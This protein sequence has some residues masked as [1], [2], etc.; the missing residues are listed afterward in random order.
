MNLDKLQL[1]A[2]VAVSSA[3]KVQWFTWWNS[4]TLRHEAL[5][6][7][8]N[9]FPDKE[10]EAWLNKASFWAGVQIPLHVEHELVFKA[11]VLVAASGP[12]SHPRRHRRTSGR[13]GGAAVVQ[14]AL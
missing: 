5:R 7:P 13:G 2:T 10:F 1:V 12:P 14:P 3:V 4:N 9:P 11:R 8:K 6:F